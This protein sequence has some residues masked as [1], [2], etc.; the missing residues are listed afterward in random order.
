MKRIKVYHD[1]TGHI[2]SDTSKRYV[3]NIQ[4]P[5][6]TNTYSLSVGQSAFSYLITG[7]DKNNTHSA[8]SDPTITMNDSDILAFTINADSPSK[9]LSISTTE[10]G[11]IVPPTNH[12][13]LNN[14]I[15]SG[16]L[17]WYPGVGNTGTFFYRATNDTNFKGTITVS[18]GNSGGMSL[19]SAA[20]IPSSG[21]LTGTTDTFYNALASGNVNDVQYTWSLSGTTGNASGV[22]Y[23][24]KYRLQTTNS[25]GL[26]GQSETFFVNVSIS[27]SG[28]NSTVTGTGV[29]ILTHTSG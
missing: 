11:T 26:A 8:A 6:I 13:L 10:T 9:P 15:D 23:D 20:V 2:R 21:N 3:A 17:K 14:S 7:S 5:I 28:A 22:A 12:T 18:A 19:T 4:K 16:V 29:V 27:S 1:G 25:T 24:S